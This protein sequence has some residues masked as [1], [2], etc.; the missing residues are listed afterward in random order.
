VPREHLGAGD[1]FFDFLYVLHLLA[2]LPEA[3][4]REGI[5]R[6]EGEHSRRKHN[7]QVLFDIV[8]H[9]FCSFLFLVFWFFSALGDNR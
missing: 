7:G 1:S 6:H 8:F 4:D 5:E 9:L 2:A 3:H